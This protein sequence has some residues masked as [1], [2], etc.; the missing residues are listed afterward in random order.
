MAL[1]TEK[2]DELILEIC[3]QNCAAL[4]TSPQKFLKLLPGALQSKTSDNDADARI[5]NFIQEFNPTLK[6]VDKM[7]KAIENELDAKRCIETEDFQKFLDKWKSILETRCENLNAQWNPLL[8]ELVKYIQTDYKTG[9]EKFLKEEEKLVEKVVNQIL[10]SSKN[11]K[12]IN[13]NSAEKA[14]ISALNPNTDLKLYKDKLDNLK[15]KIKQE[16]YDTTAPKPRVEIPQES[17]DNNDSTK[18]DSENSN[19]EKEN[20]ESS[21][22][23]N[24]DL[25]TLETSHP[26]N[27]EL[28]TLE[29]SHPDNKELKP[30]ESSHPNNQDLKSP[31]SM[32]LLEKG[33]KKENFRFMAEAFCILA[34]LFTVSLIIVIQDS[35]VQDPYLKPEKSKFNMR[36]TTPLFVPI[37]LKYCCDSSIDLCSRPGY[38][39]NSVDVENVEFFSDVPV[40][41]KLQDKLNKL[42]LEIPMLP[43]MWQCIMGNSK[44]IECASFGY[45]I[46]KFASQHMLF[47]VA[48]TLLGCGGYYCQLF[49]KYFFYLR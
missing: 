5:N 41:F 7:K 2:I 18:I 49:V 4:A 46:E 20:S 37:S 48:L 39:L 3:T 42:I 47:N 21:D 1:S 43:I 8:Q 23:D 36:C 38:G 32:K 10:A 6:E 45:A 14:F 33:S 24:K 44:E 34:Y 11:N 25:K 40:G 30:L 31:H 28:K 27:K 13:L 35:L 26:N 19:E 22:P 29:S 17:S 16:L 9:N 15:Q 12:K